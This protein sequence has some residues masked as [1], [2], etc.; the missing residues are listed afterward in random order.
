MLLTRLNPTAN[1]TATAEPHLNAWELWAFHVGMALRK[2]YHGLPWVLCAGRTKFDFFLGDGFPVG[3]M[4]C[5]LVFQP[6]TG[7][8]GFVDGILM[9]RKSR[10]SIAS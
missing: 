6:R 4:A 9:G 7:S 1:I 3:T 8:F 2:D 5:N 10:P